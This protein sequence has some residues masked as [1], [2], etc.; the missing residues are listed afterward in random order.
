MSGAKFSSRGEPPSPFHSLDSFILHT[1]LSLVTPIKDLH[2]GPCRLVYT[3]DNSYFVIE[4]EIHFILSSG[5]SHS[6]S[7]LNQTID[8]TLY[9]AHI[10]SGH[11][12][13][14]VRRNILEKI[15]RVCTCYALQS[16][17]QSGLCVTLIVLNSNQQLLEIYMPT[18][19]AWR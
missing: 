14:Q 10:P 5:K 16:G 15:S 2:P 12:H 8:H 17:S 9:H 3:I 19:M 6:S 11:T 1:G 13:H 4:N 18:R 7:A